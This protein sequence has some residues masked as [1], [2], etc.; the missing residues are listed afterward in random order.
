MI[1]IHIV[2]ENGRVIDIFTVESRIEKD[3]ENA[4]KDGKIKSYTI[5]RL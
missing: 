4:K 1:D 5:E 2:Y 3:L